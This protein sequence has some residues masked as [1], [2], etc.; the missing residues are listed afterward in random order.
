M[1]NPKRSGT[2]HRASRKLQVCVIDP[3]PAGK[4]SSRRLGLGS[5]FQRRSDFSCARQCPTDVGVFRA[6]LEGDEPVAMLA[7]DLKTGPDLLRALPE[8]L[9]ALR[10]FNSDFFINHEIHPKAD[11]L[12]RTLSDC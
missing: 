1:P 9:G 2:A 12:M 4:A 8:Y 7:V 5:H 11:P 6:E 3:A 10:A